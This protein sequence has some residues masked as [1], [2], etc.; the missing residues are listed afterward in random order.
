MG[1]SQVANHQRSHTGAVAE[2]G[3]QILDDWPDEL[4]VTALETSNAAQSRDSGCSAPSV[5]EG[6]TGGAALE[7]PLCAL[8]AQHLKV[9]LDT[10]TARSWVFPSAMHVRAYQFAIVQRALT[11]NTLVCLPTGLGKTL[12]AA[13]VMLNYMRWYPEGI[14]VFVAPTRPLVHQQM[15]A[16]YQSAG[17]PP[18]LTEEL[19]GHTRLSVRR[20]LWCSRRVFFLT[21]QVMMNDVLRHACPVERI[22]CVVFDEAHRAIGRYAYCGVVQEIERA[23]QGRFRILALTATPGSNTSCIQQVLTN[24]RIAHIEFRHE[25]D[26]DVLPYTHERQVHVERVPMN[27]AIAGILNDFQRA[28]AAPLQKLCAHGA[29]YQRNPDKVQHYQLVI[30]QRRWIEASRLQA[31]VDG[32]VSTRF[33]LF[34]DFGHALVLCRGAEFLRAH[35]LET[36][37]HYLEQETAAQAKS[38]PRSSTELARREELQALHLQVKQLVEHGAR[39]PKIE[40]CRELVVQHFLQHGS[41]STRVMIFVQYRDVVAELDAAL[42]R[43]APTVRPASFIGQAHGGMT[44]PEQRRI[45]RLFRQGTYNCLVSTSIGEEGLDIG[46]VDLIISFDALGSPIR[47]LQRMGRTGRARAGQVIVLVSESSEAQRFEDMNRRANS[48][49]GTLRDKYNKF[50]FFKQSPLMLP[51]DVGPIRCQMISVT[52]N[53][54]ETSSQAVSPAEQNKTKRAQATPR[55][56]RL[57]DALP[58]VGSQLEW[59]RQRPLLALRASNKT[60]AL[61]TFANDPMRCVEAQYRARCSSQRTMLWITIHRL[62]QRFLMDAREQRVEAPKTRPEDSS[63]AGTWTGCGHGPDSKSAHPIGEEPVRQ[64]DDIIHPAVHDIGRSP[65]Q[66]L[67][68]AVNRQ[69]S[70]AASKAASGVHPP[71]STTTGEDKWTAFGEVDENADA[72]VAALDRSSGRL[73]RDLDTTSSRVAATSSPLNWDK[74]FPETLLCSGSPQW[75][76]SPRPESPERVLS[77]RSTAS[78]VNIPTPPGAYPPGVSQ[79]SDCF[80][81][82][83]LQDGGQVRTN[84][85]QTSEE[86]GPLLR[87]NATPLPPTSCNESSDITTGF[88]SL[89]VAAHFRSAVDVDDRSERDVTSMPSTQIV[90]VNPHDDMAEQRDA[91]DSRHATQQPR[92]T[93][94]MP[95]PTQDADWDQALFLAAA[96]MEDSYANEPSVVHSNTGATQQLQLQSNAATERQRNHAAIGPESRSAALWMSRPVAA[97][98]SVSDS[99]RCIDKPAAT[100][101]TRTIYSGRQRRARLRR[102]LSSTPNSPVGVDNSQ[103]SPPGVGNNVEIAA[104][105]AAV[106]GGRLGSP[107]SPRRGRRTRRVPLIEASSDSATTD[108]TPGTASRCLTVA[109]SFRQTQAWPVLSTKRPRPQTCRQRRRN[110]A[111]AAAFIDDEADESGQSVDAESDADATTAPRH[112]T[113]DSDEQHT[114]TPGSLREF[115]TSQATSQSTAEHRRQRSIYLRSLRSPLS[116]VFQM[117]SRVGDADHIHDAEDND[118]GDDCKRT[119]QEQ[120]EHV[121]ETWT[122]GPAVATA[123]TSCYRCGRNQDPH[124]TLLCDGCEIEC[125]TYCCDPPYA[126]IPSGPWYC[127]RC[128]AYR[129]SMRVLVHGRMMVNT[130]TTII[131]EQLESQSPSSVL[132]PC[133][134]LEADYVISPRIAVFYLAA[135]GPC[136]QEKWRQC[137]EH[138]ATLYAR[139]VVCWACNSWT[140]SSPRGLLPATLSTSIVLLRCTGI[141]QTAQRIIDLASAEHECG[142]G[143]VWVPPSWPDPFQIAIQFLQQVASISL[144]NAMFL[145]LKYG[146]IRE[147]LQHGHGCVG[148]DHCLSAAPK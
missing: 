117:A 69:A 21:P 1:G 101:Q 10:E 16:C 119:A 109:H 65:L 48:I 134:S 145:L 96:I 82:D 148:D 17:I 106:A 139:V 136:D 100:H 108:P 80:Q 131:R 52:V 127:P 55:L 13:V 49:M 92:N 36:C 74:C 123:D 124:C 143:L 118:D 23:T 89:E 43:A 104:V 83:M 146:T 14:V 22:V 87:H 94:A 95:R 57:I 47:M 116:P 42:S 115:L 59:P 45:M 85:T 3:N 62:V 84:C 2:P 6:H 54:L 64:K 26:P 67:G 91:H 31:T 137:L 56:L 88:L 40:R 140:L 4:L 107:H 66:P 46:H 121:T 132:I 51:A 37:L 28:L 110:R 98:P 90:S 15:Q 61:A 72:F 122:T 75:S 24:L 53:R 5:S 129:R 126:S 32:S 133:P 71:V 20:E 39:H 102:L 77:I 58:G 27:A 19:T 68:A 120:E 86:R 60:L 114:D 135:D 7:F 41:D 130:L 97:S 73:Q 50:T 30:A 63:N 25:R 111:L 44:Q 29:F 79:P 70:A 9:P 93:E 12:I 11:R 147:A 76:A 125:H 33:S 105:D 138:A 112:A 99:L 35:G 144:P 8:N 141:R 103:Q 38:N 34:R 128:D 142:Y 113:M 18:A 81:N 78:M